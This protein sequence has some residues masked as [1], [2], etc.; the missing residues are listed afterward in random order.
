MR[1]F[2]TRW[3]STFIF[4]SFVITSVTGVL[5]YLHIRLPPTEA[6]HIWIG[7]LMVA[8]GLFHIVRNWRQFLGYFRRPPFYAALVVTAL[9][10]AW[11]SYPVLFGTQTASEGGRPNLR[12]AFAI[13]QAVS[14]ASLADLAPLAK[15]DASGLMAKLSGMGIAVS[16]PSASLQS[17]AEFCRPEPAGTGRRAHRR[18]GRDRQAGLG[19]SQRRIPADL[20]GAGGPSSC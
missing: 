15:T 11:F 19:A 17:V 7:F 16:D 14:S 3:G 10:S 13:S 18:R 12:A 6:L 4:A 1:Q 20:K 5:L 9:I 2:V 8:A